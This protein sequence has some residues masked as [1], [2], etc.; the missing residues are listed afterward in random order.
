MAKFKIIKEFVLNGI[1]Q[2]VDSIVEFDNKKASLKSIQENIEKVVIDT[3]K[4]ES[5]L[6]G[7]T[8][9]ETLTPEQ[10]EKLIKEN[11]SETVNAQNLAA[12]HRARDIAEGKGE[13]AVK[14]I[15]DA[16]KDKLANE[17]FQ[18]KENPAPAPTE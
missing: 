4:G 10:K 11:I 17:E 14:V 3:P 7:I 18:N 16:L 9:G 13:P 1:V 5:A 12:E 15:A 6:S 2:K 8:P